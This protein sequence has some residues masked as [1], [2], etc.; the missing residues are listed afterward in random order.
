MTKYD[1]HQTLHVFYC[2]YKGTFIIDWWRK[3]NGI[4]QKRSS[5][6]HSS[7]YFFLVVMV[8]RVHINCTSCWQLLCLLRFLMCLPHCLTSEVVLLQLLSHNSEIRNEL[9][10]WHLLSFR[11]VYLPLELNRKHVWTMMK[12]FIVWVRGISWLGKLLHLYL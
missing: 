2:T 4:C 3:A 6:S 5:F 8:V 9:S 7:W 12:W 10:G 1:I 11:V